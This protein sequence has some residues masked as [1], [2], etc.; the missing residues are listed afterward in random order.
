[1]SEPGD[2]METTD[3]THLPGPDEPAGRRTRRRRSR[4][5]RCGST[6]S[7]ARSRRPPRTSCSTSATWP[8]PTPASSAVH[9]VTLPIYRNEITALIGPSGCGKTTVPPLPQP[10]ERPD[11]DRSRRGHAPVPRR[12][13]VRR[14]PSTRSRCAGASAWCS[15]SRTRS[16]SRSTTT[17]RSARRSPASRATWTSSS[18]SRSARAALWDEVKDKLKE[19]GSRSRAGSSSGCASRGRSRRGRT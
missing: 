2:Q 11:R 18:R 13:P 8:C 9:K 6:A 3:L 19:S 1:M 4:R 16:R 7:P 12:R 10:D 14:V 15:R 17:S 5:S